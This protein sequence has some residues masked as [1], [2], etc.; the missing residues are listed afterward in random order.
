[1]ATHNEP[2]NS[3]RHTLIV[4]LEPMI[5]MSASA[6]EVDLVAEDLTSADFELIVL[7]ETDVPVDSAPEISMEPVLFQLDTPF[8]SML[9]SAEVTSLDQDI[10]LVDAPVMQAEGEV[11]ATAEVVE[12]M[13]FES[14]IPSEEPVAVK[15]EVPSFE[16]TEPLPME[17]VLDEPQFE[18]VMVREPQVDTTDVEVV[19]FVR[20]AEPEFV[21]ASSMVELQTLEAEEIVAEQKP[22]VDE[23]LQFAD[24]SVDA[25]SELPVE[26]RSSVEGTPIEVTMVQRETMMPVAT[27]SAELEPAT[28]R[29]D[30][31]ISLSPG[32]YF[33]GGNGHDILIGLAGDNV[34]KGDSGHDMIILVRGDN[35]VDGGIGQDTLVYWSGNRSEYTFVD[36]GFGIIEVTH[37]QNV[38][39]LTSIEEVRFD[40]GTFK[41]ADLL[42]PAVTVPAPEL[43]VAEPIVMVD[44]SSIVAEIS[45]APEMPVIVPEPEM[46]IDE[47]IV[48]VDES[49]VVAEIP[50][51]PEMEVIVPEPE[52]IV[53]E[54]IVVVDETATSEVLV[55]EEILV[56]DNSSDA[57]PVAAPDVTP[58]ST[59]PVLPMVTQEELDMLLIQNPEPATST[60]L[61]P[62]DNS[63]DLNTVVSEVPTSE[64]GEVEVIVLDE[65]D[66]LLWT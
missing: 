37:G 3:T 10:L 2:A 18:V 66:L 61:P 38:D 5:L 27:T 43:I 54:L 63:D 8:D 40:D 11:F 50:P 65:S 19:D 1:M 20:I 30:F 48:V 41:I 55:S 62:V 57:S 15:E 9:M 31:R 29:N 26:I 17:F 14:T 4:S 52:M 7:T 58:D 56:A 24:E 45:P 23:S 6:A 36:K 64:F 22:I 25:P 46:I 47:P 51:A 59:L 42:T 21:D 28:D 13:S 44:E 16:S 32:E 39:Y 33:N 53:D 12:S 34:L 35:V 49:A 60:E